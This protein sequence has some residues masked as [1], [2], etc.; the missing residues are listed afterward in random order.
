[1]EIKVKG[2]P[3]LVVQSN[4]DPAKDREHSLTVNGQGIKWTGP[5]GVW[6]DGKMIQ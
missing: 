1:M 5:F 2:K 3:L 6:F 4:S